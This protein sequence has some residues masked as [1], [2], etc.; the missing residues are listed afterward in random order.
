MMVRVLVRLEVESTGNVPGSTCCGESMAT[1]VQTYFLTLDKLREVVTERVGKADAD[2]LVTMLRSL[3]LRLPSRNLMTASLDQIKTAGRS[4]RAGGRSKSELRLLQRGLTTFF[5]LAYSQGLI[6]YHPVRRM[7]VAETRVK[8]AVLAVN[9]GSRQLGHLSQAL[10]GSSHEIEVEGSP[11][12][13]VEKA[14]LYAFQ[15]VISRYPLPWPGTEELLFKMRAHDS[16]SVH[17]G[18]VLMAP[19][20]EFDVA[21]QLVG[22]GA[23]RVVRDDSPSELQTALVELQRVTP[24]LKLRLPIRVTTTGHFDDTASMWQSENISMTGLL[25]RTQQQLERGTRVACDFKLPGDSRP[26]RSRAE[27]VRQ[28]HSRR[29]NLT[30]IGARFLSFEGDGERRLQ[31]FVSSRLYR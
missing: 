27:V 4:M 5:D 12:K 7:G 15:L 20:H 24:R 19:A 8:P 18:L 9:L 26:I 22:L 29:E 17:A 10:G 13:A 14:R 3:V 21:R 11:K 23:N 2:N 6:A 30:G 28:A 31:T 1:T 16:L 25:I